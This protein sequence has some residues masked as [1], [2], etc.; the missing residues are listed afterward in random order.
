MSSNASSCSQPEPLT[1]N[2][3][4]K[5]TG[6]PKVDSKFPL[7][8]RNGKFNSVGREVGVGLNTFDV[9]TLPVKPVQ[10][11]DITIVNDKRTPTR[12]VQMK[13]WKSKTMGQA[14]GQ[15]SWLFDGNKLAW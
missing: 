8:K 9:T 5:L 15:G 4:N 2:H 13:V 6:R 12:M 3:R 10:Q 11:Y 1:F 14:L 7:P